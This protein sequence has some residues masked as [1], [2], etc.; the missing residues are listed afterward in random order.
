MRLGD[1]VTIDDGCLVDGRGAGPGGFVLGDGVVVN[2]NCMLVAKSG[3]LTMGPRT[4]IGSNS[5]IISLA[6]RRAGR[7]GAAG[8]RLLPER[9]RLPDARPTPA[10]HGPGRGEQGADPDRRRRVA[11]HLRRRLD[12]VSVGKGAVVGAGAIVTKDVPDWAIVAGVP[13]RTGRHAGLSGGSGEETCAGSLASLAADTPT[14]R[15]RAACC[16]RCGTAGRTTRICTS[17]AAPT[18]GHRRLSIIDLGGG[19]QPIG[20][21]DGTRWIVCNGEIYNYRELM[22]ELEEKGHRFRTRSD[23]EVIL[24]LYEEMGEAC[25]DRLRGMFAFAI[26]DENEQR[27]FA[28]RDH[29]GQKPFFYRHAGGE[30]AFASE[31]KGLLPLLPGRPE[32][33]RAALHQYLA[34]RIVASPLSMFREVA[35]LPPAH[36]LSFSARDGLRIRRYWDLPYEPKLKGSEEELLDALE[37]RLI[38]AVRLHMVATCRWARS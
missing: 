11:R 38:E 15:P 26:W 28:A 7:G 1:Q 30:L 9:R 31:I 10:D 23:T 22:R 18:L 34:L 24:H 37:E 16:T 12:G 35:K 36:C 2:R 8:G 20:N 19:R 6:G 27:L 21:E 25:L 3:G 4:S 14:R 33:D 29:L 5:V 17:P 13:A 32:V